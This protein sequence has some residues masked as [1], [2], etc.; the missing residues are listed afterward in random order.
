MTRLRRLA[1]FAAVLSLGLLPLGLALAA[2]P[3][4]GFSLQS[5]VAFS[6]PAS[7]NVLT[8]YTVPIQPSHSVAYTAGTAANQINKGAQAGGSAAASAATIDLSTVT[9]VDGTTGLSH[10]REYVIYNDSTTA[11]LTLDLTVSNSLKEWVS[12]GTGTKLTIEPGAVFRVSKPKGTNGYVVDS[13]HKIVT[14]DPGA[15]TVA[16]RAIFLGD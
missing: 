10:V 12:A 9:C 14:L 11:A 7:G 4:G 15:N 2:T 8:A 16:Y 1:V 5:N 13:T 3:S 6:V